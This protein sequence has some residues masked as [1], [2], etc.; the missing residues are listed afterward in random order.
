MTMIY[1]VVMYVL[2]R[3]GANKFYPYAITVLFLAL[4]LA[5]LPGLYAFSGL[6]EEISF[7][8]T[9]QSIFNTAAFSVITVFI[10]ILYLFVRFVYAIVKTHQAK[11]LEEHYDRCQNFG[12]II[13]Y[14]F[15]FL[16]FGTHM[17]VLITFGTSEGIMDVTFAESRVLQ[18]FF[19]IILGALSVL[20]IICLIKCAVGMRKAWK[21]KK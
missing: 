8:A 21:E 6:S 11:E 16:M 17:I 13:S 4:T 9:V 15:T 10:Y 3:A 18:I 1:M 20:D 14:F 7:V 2:E 5:V 12:D 19:M